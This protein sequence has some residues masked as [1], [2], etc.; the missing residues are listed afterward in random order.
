MSIAL[1]N[2]GSVAE[3]R[4][5]VACETLRPGDFRWLDENRA[6]NWQE[7]RDWLI[8]EPRLRNGRVLDI[9]CGRSTPRGW[10]EIEQIAR[11]IDG[12][13][14]DP[15]V[16][17]HPALTR[18]WHGEFESADIPQS[19]YDVAYASY[20]TEHIESARPFFEQVAR[21]LKPGGVFM[22]MTPNATHPFAAI[23]RLIQS[24]VGKKIWAKFQ[25]NINRYPAYY[26]LNSPGQVLSALEGLPF[27]SAQFLY[28]PC[29]HW[30]T[31]FPRV[32]RWAPHLYDRMLGVRFGPAMLTLYMRLVRE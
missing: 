15:A 25:D 8:H 31:Y 32:L 27:S 20:V 11:R 4:L 23:S 22:A 2:A 26:R 1:L 18:R 12:V 24:T 29:V 7:M 3:A 28:V 17:S 30:D 16:L 13:D 14:P 19:S 9:G 5:D 10:V 6:S 21:V